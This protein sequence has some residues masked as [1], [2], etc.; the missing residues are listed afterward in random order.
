MFYFIKI[1]FAFLTIFIPLVL[2][3]VSVIGILRWS[4]HNRK[5]KW[6]FMAIISFSIAFSIA[7]LRIYSIHIEPNM[8][9]VREAKIVSPKIKSEIKIIHFSDIQADK[10]D[11]FE[12]KL[13][14][15]IRSISPD[16][17]LYTGDFLQVLDKTKE[18][19]ELSKL[20]KLFQTL[21]PSMGTFGVF[22]N[23]DDPLREKIDAG[24][25]GIKM[26]KSN[27]AVLEN[28]GTRLNIFGLDYN[29]T[30]NED[31]TVELVQG[32]LDTTAPTDF[33]IL[34]G[35]RPGFM[36]A[37]N[38]MPIDLCLA[39]HV[40]GGQVRIPFYGPIITLAKI[41]RS[42]TRGFREVGRTRINVSAGVGC[43]RAS[44]APC[45]RFNCPPEITLI[46]LAPKK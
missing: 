14:E 12:I 44:G 20:D 37:V 23:I 17:I 46:T 8:L 22:G 35:H 6:L 19:G 9:I 11:L 16:L 36:L 30:K 28:D 5:R 33:T 3:A 45:I 27:G 7:A 4:G 31:A 15:Q 43:E 1:L 24:F 34:M 10:V 18:E 26:L 32:R 38:E 2:T 40:H 13:F 25:G 21:N 42:W 39:G 41:P 29:S